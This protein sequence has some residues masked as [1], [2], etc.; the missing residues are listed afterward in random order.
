MEL[1]G[2]AHGRENVIMHAMKLIPNRAGS[3]KNRILTK[4]GLSRSIQESELH[5]YLG[6]Q[7]T[8]EVGIH[9][10]S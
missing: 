3:F 10:M 6:G 8:L 5:N 9:E 7:S 2:A 4:R 1:Y